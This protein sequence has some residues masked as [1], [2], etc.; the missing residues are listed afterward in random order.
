M[1]LQERVLKTILE[2]PG[3]SK[4]RIARLF[5]LSSYRLHRVFRHIERDL[6]G[7]TIVHHDENG[8]WLVE[9]DPGKCMGTLWAGALGGG[10]RQCS[11]NPEFKDKRCYEHSEC[12]NPEMVAFKRK[13]DYL[14]GPAEP[15]VFHLSH[16]TMAIVE[17]LI[18]RL[19]KIA[20][21]TLRDQLEKDRFRGLLE[22][23]LRTL[24][25]KDRVRQ[26]RSR[27]RIP[28]EFFERHRRSSGNT[29]DYSLRQHFL[30]LEVAS[31]ATRQQVLNAW[32]RLAR[33]HHPDS[34]SGDEERMKAINLAKEKIFRIKRWD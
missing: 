20:P 3:S 1:N 26:R 24:R 16:L 30:V 31:D 6:Q 33:R 5:D 19:K 15:T 23:A 21:L 8:V 34:A 4:K 28:P 32:R 14:T 18:E 2:R 13:L 29:F 25:W 10:Y 11:K 17:N 12:Q 27:D 9:M 7:Q 22:A